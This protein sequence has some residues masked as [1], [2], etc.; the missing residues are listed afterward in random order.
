M[1]LEVAIL[2]IKEGFSAEFEINFKKA[3][4]IISSMKGYISHKLKK[5]IEVK[6]KYILLVNWETLE[7]HEIGFRKSHEYKE[8]KTLLHHFYEPFPTVEHYK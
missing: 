7:D 4:T 1:I 3:E 2:N 8:W 5:C 6:D